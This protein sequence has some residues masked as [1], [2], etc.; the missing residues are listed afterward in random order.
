MELYGE[1]DLHSNNNVKV[2]NSLTRYDF[3]FCP[4]GWRCLH[5]LPDGIRV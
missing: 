4:D 2:M 5:R 1:I 3:H